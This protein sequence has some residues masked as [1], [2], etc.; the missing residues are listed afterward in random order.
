MAGSADVFPLADFHL[1]IVITLLNYS[2]KTF[3]GWIRPVAP[4]QAAS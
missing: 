3:Y 2:N 4:F 1:N